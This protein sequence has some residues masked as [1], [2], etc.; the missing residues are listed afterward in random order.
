MPKGG[1]QG[2]SG[3]RQAKRTV[4]AGGKKS[5]GKVQAK[6]SKGGSKKGKGGS[7]MTKRQQQLAGDEGQGDGEADNEPLEFQVRPLPPKRFRKWGFCAYLA[8]LLFFL[9]LT[10]KPL[11]ADTSFYNF[12]SS[13]MLMVGESDF[14]R[15]GNKG[16]YFE[17]FSYSFLPGLASVSFLRGEISPIALVGLPR[18]R[19]VRADKCDAG[20]AGQWTAKACWVSP[21]PGQCIEG[22]GSEC[23][24]TFGSANQYTFADEERTQDQPHV[25]WDGSESY[26]GTGF[27]L[28][29][30]TVRDLLKSTFM[31]ANRTVHSSGTEF[32]MFPHASYDTSGLV[33]SGWFDPQT[34]ALFHDFTIVASGS[35]SLYLTP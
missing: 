9:L 30:D 3:A 22:S 32:Y 13:V 14:Y 24:K 16:E 29:D 31:G 21:A 19:Q 15:V 7:K 4:G 6:S 35:Q 20:E 27:L 8:F 1:S 17:W 11:Q 33:A 28:P 2:K 25:S 26:P 12:A 5:A 23:S 18:I 10:F 34:T